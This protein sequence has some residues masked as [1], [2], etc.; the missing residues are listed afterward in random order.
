MVRASSTIKFTVYREHVVLAKVGNNNHCCGEVE[1]ELQ[2]VLTSPTASHKLQ[3]HWYS[4]EDNLELSV[5]L[6]LEP[7]FC[8]DSLLDHAQEKLQRNVSRSTSTKSSRAMSLI[9]FAVENIDQV[10]TIV[11][12]L[13]EIH[14]MCKVAWMVLGSVYKAFKNERE[15]DD[16]ARSLAQELQETLAYA[17]ECKDLKAIPGATD[18]LLEIAKL[19]VQSAAAFDA[20]IKHSIATRAM[21]SAASKANQK[22]IA[23]C[24]D[25][26]KV[27]RKKLHETLTIRIYQGQTML[28]ANHGLSNNGSSQ[29]LPLQSQMKTPERSTLYLPLDNRHRPGYSP[30]YVSPPV[31]EPYQAVLQSPPP[32]HVFFS[33][34]DDLRRFTSSPE[35]L[36]PS[37]LM[38]SSP[39]PTFGGNTLPKLSS[40][41][42]PTWS[43]WPISSRTPSLVTDSGRTLSSRSSCSSLSES[44]TCSP[45]DP[46]VYSPGGADDETG[47]DGS[48]SNPAIWHSKDHVLLE[49][50][51]PRNLQFH[52]LVKPHASHVEPRI[53]MPIPTS[54]S[55]RS[56]D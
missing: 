26:L 21:I 44:Y 40:L 41:P 56:S 35:P 36:D 7:T 6:Q 50:P 10:V 5:Q 2:A 48:S 52:E 47:G 54:W 17:K 39:P 42:A 30:I 14:P 12:G 38:P 23:T 55:H 1:M 34:Q 45:P 8:Q 29:F 16:Q 19:V 15:L 27:L 51:A 9:G 28:L 46:A 43:P 49:P 11:D 53:A 31:D 20:H 24:D 32:A 22:R 25:K 33:S 18:V 37:M 13:A 4:R 3:S